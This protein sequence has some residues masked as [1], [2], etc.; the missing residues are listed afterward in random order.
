MTIM[1]FG[2]KNRRGMTVLEVTVALSLLAMGLILTAQVFTACARQELT[3]EQ[4][5][6][7]QCEADNVL[8]HFEGLR[9]EE[10][11]AQAAKDMKPSAELLAA[12]PEAKVEVSV[13]ESHDGEGAEAGPAHKRIH[14]EVS[15]PSE[16]N[17]PRAVKLTA[18][19]YPAATNAGTAPR[20]AAP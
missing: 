10:V 14:V 2:N 15:W 9:Y 5:L 4:L 1:E 3:S 12:L 20:E 6:V 16:D 13:D 19:K 11:T 17:A 7:A 18:W 8:E